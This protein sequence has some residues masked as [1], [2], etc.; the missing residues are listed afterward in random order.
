MTG[1]E[2]HRAAP[3]DPEAPQP[4]YRHPWVWLI[5][6]IP[7]SSVLVG[8]FMITAA[9]NTP[10]DLVQDDYYRAGVAI[11]QDLSARRRADELGLQATLQNHGPDDLLLRVEAGP[12]VV[13]EAPGALLEARLQHPTLADRDVVLRMEPVANGRWA[14]ALTRFEGTRVL[15]VTH[16]SAGWLLREEV[17][18]PAADAERPAAPGGD[19]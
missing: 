6:A 2:P 10:G 7:G 11:N 12:G 14:V 1:R 18:S 17:R 13:V 16:P 9:L 19:A 3:G 5:I 4:W 8:I 15:R